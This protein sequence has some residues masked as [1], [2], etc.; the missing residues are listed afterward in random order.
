M[1]DFKPLKN[2]STVFIL[3]IWLRRFVYGVLALGALLV[4]YII[5][6]SDIELN[7]QGTIAFNPLII[8]MLMF[9]PFLVML[10]AMSASW[11]AFAKKNSFNLVKHI[12]YPPRPGSPSEKMQVPSFRGKPLRVSLFPILGKLGSYSFGFGTRQYKEGIIRFRE[13]KMDIF[14]WID[15]PVPLPHIVV[16][17]RVN[18]KARLSNLSEHYDKSQLLHFEGAVGDRYYVYAAKGNQVGALQLFTPDVLDV[19]YTTLPQL[20]IE[21]KGRT[22]WFVWRYA[23]LNEARGEQIFKAVEIFMPD[24]EKQMLSARFTD[25]EIKKELI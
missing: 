9:A 6:G 25:E 10:F 7:I 5:F 4:A 24:F 8:I 18:E 13:R 20:D 15:L 23:V 17:S 1:I 19:L 14:M 21:V 2:Y 12:S 11:E 16:D 3:Y 22:I